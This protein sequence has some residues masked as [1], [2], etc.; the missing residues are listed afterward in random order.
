[1]KPSFESFPKVL[2]GKLLER[3]TGDSGVGNLKMAQCQHSVQHVST[4]YNKMIL[5]HC[6]NVK[7]GQS[8]KGLL[9]VQF[10]AAESLKKRSSGR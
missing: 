7:L 1:M 9:F 10:R 5:C 4:Q 6:Q 8:M 2:T 3:L